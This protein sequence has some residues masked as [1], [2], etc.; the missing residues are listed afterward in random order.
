[1]EKRVVGWVMHEPNKLS[2]EEID[3]LGDDIAM[4]AAHIDAATHQL[5]S[6]IRRFDESGGWAWQGARS[7]AHWYWRIGIGLCAARE[8]VRVARAL[9]TLPLIDAA[10]ARGELSY[11]KVRAMTRVATPENQELLLI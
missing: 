9:E 4:A 1:M 7:T 10:L 8:Q 2:R 5:L 3:R 11:A 6:S